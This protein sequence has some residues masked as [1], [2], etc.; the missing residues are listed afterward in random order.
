MK[1]VLV[2]DECRRS[3]N[4]SE[5]VATLVASDAELR[6]KPFARVTSADSFVPLAEAANLVLMQETE[7][8]EAAT[9][10]HA[11]AAGAT[12]GASHAK[13]PALSVS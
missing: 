8:E 5:A 11:A 3:G 2:A 12:G 13:Q 1:S 4:V 10:L 9:A 7:I 6:A